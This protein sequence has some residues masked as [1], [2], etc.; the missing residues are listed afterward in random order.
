M[1]VLWWLAPPLAAT[2]LAM[3][4]VAWAGRERDEPRRDDS[5]AALLRMATAL[6]K[7]APSAPDHVPVVPTETSHGV[8]V[9]GSAR[10]PDPTT[11]TPAM[12]RSSA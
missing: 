2:G 4:W 7:P 6:A 5:D 1:A 12:R 8:A 11:S 9:R 10:R 3:L